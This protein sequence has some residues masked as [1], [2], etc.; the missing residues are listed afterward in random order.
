VRGEP[1]HPDTWTH[2]WGKLVRK[3]GIDG[4]DGPPWLHD[5]RRSFITLSRRRGE[6]TTAIMKISGHATD[7]AFRR[8]NI[9]SLAD[10]LATK[11]RLESAR[12]AELREENSRRVN[13]SPDAPLAMISPASR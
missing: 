3:L 12:A 5:L 9:F 4:P 6:D 7:S 11:A 8:Y 13:T 2:R 1:E 10:I